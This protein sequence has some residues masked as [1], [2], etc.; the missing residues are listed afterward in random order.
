M[1][2]GFQDAFNLA[3]KLALILNGRGDQTKLLRSY[4]EER[5]AAAAFVLQ[6]SGGLT[7]A[8][9]QK[10]GPVARFLLRNVAPWFVPTVSPLLPMQSITEENLVLSIAYPSSSPLV[11]PTSTRKFRIW[12]MAG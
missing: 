3:W 12:P 11:G 5:R 7:T 2:T 6:R 9:T 10:F 8:L 4:S 1:N